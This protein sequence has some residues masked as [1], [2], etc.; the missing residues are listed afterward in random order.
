MLHWDLM[1]SRSLC[2]IPSCPAP[3]REAISRDESGGMVMAHT[4]CCRSPLGVLKALRNLGGVCP[5]LGPW[6]SMD[7]LDF[8]HTQSTQ[9]AEHPG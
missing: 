5:S 2:G 6:L 9:V 4:E 1:F 3:S 7:C 8:G